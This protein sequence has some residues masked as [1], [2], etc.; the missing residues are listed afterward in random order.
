MITARVRLLALVAFTLLAL[1]VT[2]PAGPLVGQRAQFNAATEIVALAVSVTDRH[3]RP[4]QGLHREDFI[5]YDDDAPQDIRVFS[6][7]PTLTPGGWIS[8]LIR[9]IL[10]SATRQPS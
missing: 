6:A 7:D 8:V 5:V 1:A 4:V 9:F 2:V 3:G 10:R